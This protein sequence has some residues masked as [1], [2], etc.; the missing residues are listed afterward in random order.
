[1][2]VGPFRIPSRLSLADALWAGLSRG[3]EG[4][5]VALG[6]A[7]G[8]TARWAQ[9]L[10][11]R[12]ERMPPPPLGARPAPEV[13]LLSVEAPAVDVQSLRTQSYAELLNYLQ[14][15]KPSPVGELR[16]QILAVEEQR[17]INDAARR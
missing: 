9:A 11:G 2:N 10:N 1:M 7:H 3:L 6:Y 17:A 4:V 14:G 8:K 5:R 15:G 16:R 13:S 12:V